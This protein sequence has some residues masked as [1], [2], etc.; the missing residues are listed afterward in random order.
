VAR[1]SHTT[2]GTIPS[3][4]ARSKLPSIDKFGRLGQLQVLAHEGKYAFLAAGYVAAIR[5]ACH[6]SHRPQQALAAIAMHVLYRSQPR[7][8][9]QCDSADTRPLHV[10]ETNMFLSKRYSCILPV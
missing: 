2:E 6:R 7:L 10:A 5:T 4:S 3:R 9:V 8:L 1:S